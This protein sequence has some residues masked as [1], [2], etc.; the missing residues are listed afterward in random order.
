VDSKTTPGDQHHCDRGSSKLACRQQSNPR[1]I[2]SAV[3]KYPEIRAA[4]TANCAPFNGG[5]PV[6][7]LSL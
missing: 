6:S 1:P 2:P 3:V 4:K 7:V 5:L